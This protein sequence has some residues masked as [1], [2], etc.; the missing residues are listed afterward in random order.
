MD[1]SALY[2]VADYKTGDIVLF[3]GRSFLSRVIQVATWSRWSH[4]GS[5]ISDDPEHQFPLLYESTHCD[6][7]VGLDSGKKQSGVQLVSLEERIKMYDGDVAIRRVINPDYSLRY[8]LTEYREKV[9][10]TPFE[11]SRWDVMASA[12]LFSFMRKGGADLS[13]IFCAEHEAEIYK[14]LGWLTTSTPSSWYYPKFFANLKSFEKGVSVGPIEM[15]KKR[16]RP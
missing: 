15:L 9:M 5:V 11:Q 16:G 1:R 8:K 10:G 14:A 2:N 12:P 13:S 4:C 6:K 3:S 7:L